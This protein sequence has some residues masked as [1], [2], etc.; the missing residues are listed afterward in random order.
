MKD[1]LAKELFVRYRNYP[2]IVPLERAYFWASTLNSESFKLLSRLSITQQLDVLIFFSQ[3]STK[4]LEGYLKAFAISGMAHPACLVIDSNGFVGIW[5]HSETRNFKFTERRKRQYKKVTDQNFSKNFLKSIS[6]LSKKID[7]N[8]YALVSTVSYFA[9]FKYDEALILE[10]MQRFIDESTS[11][12]ANDF[13][14][15][16]E[17]WAA[18]KE[19]PLS[20]SIEMI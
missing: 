5:I 8:D 9:H 19:Q 6:N 10:V 7:F 3:L 4:N 13:L 11:Y 17:N 2:K 15:L 16:L 20:W 12:D 1:D 14:K 18:A